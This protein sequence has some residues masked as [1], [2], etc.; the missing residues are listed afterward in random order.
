MEEERRRRLSL[1]KDEEAKE[2]HEREVRRQ[3]RLIAV[4]EAEEARARAFYEYEFQNNLRER[5]DMK[6][7]EQAMRLFV[8]ESKSSGGS[9]YDVGGASTKKSTKQERRDELKR[10]QA[11]KLVRERECKEMAAEDDLAMSLRTEEKKAEQLAR[12]RRPV[13]LWCLHFLGWTRGHRTRS[14]VVSFSNLR[15]FERPRCSAQAALKKEMELYALENEA[16]DST[17]IEDL[18]DDEGYASSVLSD[19][20]QEDLIPETTPPPLDEAPEE[21]RD[22]VKKERLERRKYRHR[23]RREKAQRELRKRRAQHEAEQAAVLEA[24]R[25]DAL[26]AHAKAELEWMEL[27]EEARVI[28]KQAFRARANLRKVALYC[29]GKGMDELRARYVSRRFEVLWCL[30]A[31][32]ARRLQE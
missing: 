2:A 22:R 27:E 12:S 20:S 8:L 5:R 26:I 11:Q 32:D 1:V 3:H 28:E 10:A 7:A 18:S 14:W 25:K 21:M 4:L 13:V 29:Q 19:D 31:I 16:A 17:V 24:F 15:Q 23:R 30:H 6:E 9:K